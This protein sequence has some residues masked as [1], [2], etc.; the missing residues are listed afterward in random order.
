MDPNFGKTLEN[1][2]WLYVSPFIFAFGLFG[3]IFLIIITSTRSRKGSDIVFFIRNLAIAD[4]LVLI[5]GMPPAFL[6]AADI[7]DFEEI[8]E[9][10]CKFVKFFEYTF[11][12]YAIW[13][14]SAYSVERAIA[15][16]IPL[17][18]RTL[19][20]IGRARI[21]I[22]LLLIMAVAKNFHHFWTR[23]TEVEVINGT[24]IFVS[25]CGYPTEADRYFTRF[26]RPWIVF[27]MSNVVPL[28]TI[29]FSNCAVLCALHKKKTLSYHGDD[30]SR[31][32]STN[33]ITI[34][35]LSVSLAFVICILPG[36]I[37]YIGRSYWTE[38]ETS[39]SN[40]IYT[41][42]KAVNDMLIYINH[43]INFYICILSSHNFR[44][45][46][47]EVLCCTKDKTTIANGTTSR[48]PTMNFVSRALPRPRFT[49]LKSDTQSSDTQ[50]SD[51]QSEEVNHM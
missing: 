6:R 10:S 49:N 41:I 8:D 48:I 27:V 14:I 2:L 33:H 32:R 5:F 4:L 37:L 21:C 38:D 9:W 47:Y 28:F 42:F 3:N 45:L 23:G 1:D 34:V 12:D 20:S 15:V 31:N 44:K 18:K 16:C 51:T 40:Y 35:C 24:E 29:I 17:K 25:N 26:V 43:S 11:M 46:S 22:I 30:Q 19:C 13:V 7:I 50:N 39:Q 36:V